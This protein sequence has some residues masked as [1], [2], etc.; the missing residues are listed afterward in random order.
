MNT[1]A[2]KQAGRIKAAMS[3]KGI[4][5]LSKTHGRTKPVP[6][7]GLRDLK[8][9]TLFALVLIF[10]LFFGDIV[11]A[12]ESSARAFVGPAPFHATIFAKPGDMTEKYIGLKSTD[13]GLLVEKRTCCLDAGDGSAPTESVYRFYLRSEKD[14]LIMV[15]NS[16]ETVLLD[17]AKDSWAAPMEIFK[18]GRGTY[19][20][21]AI[22]SVESRETKEL[23]GQQRDIIGVRCKCEPK[24]MPAITVEYSLA[25][26]L[27]LVEI[28]GT[29]LTD[30][31]DT[32]IGQQ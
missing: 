10:T 24:D 7:S 15:E 31:I 11:L 17:L 29:Q 26:G 9:R 22:C 12:D 13:S 30:A 2:Q 23:F 1:G 6:L 27:G 21:Q 19:T 25:S 4:R 28:N 32:R 20:L 3:P 14:R 5:L 8:G 18:P 16:R